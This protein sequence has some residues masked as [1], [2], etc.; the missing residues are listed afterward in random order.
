MEK[1]SR[2]ASETSKL[3]E[4][5]KSQVNRLVQQL[6]DLEDVRADMDEAEFEQ[7]RQETLDEMKEFE[8][9]VHKTVSGDMSLVDEL[10]SIQLVR[11]G[12]FGRPGSRWCLWSARACV[13]VCVCVV[14]RQSKRR[15]PRRSRR[16]R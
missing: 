3:V 11:G 6:E 7:M 10:G 1:M 16:R 8:K 14:C 15:W 13:C 4:Q 12:L 5:I 9:L 2:G